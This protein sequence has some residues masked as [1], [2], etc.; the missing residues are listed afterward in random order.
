MNEF[1][2]VLQKTRIAGVQ[3][4]TF[5]LTLIVILVSLLLIFFSKQCLSLQ[6]CKTILFFMSPLFFMSGCYFICASLSEV[7]SIL[8][9]RC[10]FQM[11]NMTVFEGQISLN[12]ITVLSL[13]L[14]HPCSI[15]YRSI[16]FTKN[17][18]SHL[19]NPAVLVP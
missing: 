19:M 7:M 14:P 6:C 12:D 5:L 3:K 2:T 1:E 17:I 11:K 4:M 13:P 9:V 10:N 18:F 8:Q 15:V 16:F